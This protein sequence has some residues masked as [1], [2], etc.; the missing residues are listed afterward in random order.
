MKSPSLFIAG[1]GPVGLTAALELKRRGFEP[2]I[3]DPDPAPSPESRAL[4]IN[5][6][7]LDLLQHSGVTDALL[8]AGVR[9]KRLVIRR[10]TRAIAEVDLTKIPHRFNFLLVLAQ[11]RTEAILAEHL[12][13]AGVVLE[14]NLGLSTFT[15]GTSSPDTPNQLALSDGSTTTA[16]ILIGADGSHSITRKTLGLDFPGETQAE[17]FGLADVELAN[18]PYPFDT[19]V[20]SILDTHLAPFIPMAEGYG[21]FIST[22]G[23]CLGSLPPDAK[24]S[25]IDWQTDFRISYR[26]VKSYQRGNVFLVGD[27]AHIHSP[28]GGRGMNLGIEDAC[29]LAWLIEQNRTAEFTALRHPVGAKVLR[30]THQFTQLAKARS[31][32]QDFLLSTLIPLLT[33]IAPIRD[34]MFNALTA[35]D[36]PAPRW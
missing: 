19:M 31:G 25:R 2:R 32:L 7:T 35:L 6:R 9:V 30:F 34:R 10:G 17:V 4:A 13:K 36:T 3:V 28:V 33:R 14:R 23:D 26:Q 15:P 18:W 22:R 29:W 16:D 8:A 1:G 24:V 5:S 11:S 20:L 21:R 27:A 12:N